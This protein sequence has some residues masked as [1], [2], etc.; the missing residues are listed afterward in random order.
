[1]RSGNSPHT[2]LLSVAP[3]FSLLLSFLLFLVQRGMKHLKCILLVPVFRA[4]E[5]AQSAA[6]QSLHYRMILLRCLQQTRL[7]T[8][9]S[10][11]LTSTIFFT[12]GSSARSDRNIPICSQDS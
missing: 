9:L 4:Q 12:C 8:M 7:I 2:R 5:A 11:M 6:R 3:R 10:L 1:H